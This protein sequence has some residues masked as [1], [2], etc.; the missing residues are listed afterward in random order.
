HVLL[1]GLL[2]PDALERWVKVAQIVQGLVTPAAAIVIGVFTWRIQHQQVRTQH[3]QYRFT[4]IERRMKV[5]DSTM[6]F[7]ALVLRDSTISTLEPL[8]KLLRE[9]REHH[10]LFGPEI[11]KYINELY[12]SGVRLHTI[13]KTSQPTGVIRPEDIPVDAEILEWFSGQSRV[14]EQIFLKYMDFRQP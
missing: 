9:T 14:A 3:L 4:V 1:F 12:G 6:E 5:F 7:I 2:R 10:L 11:G 8:I 13:Y